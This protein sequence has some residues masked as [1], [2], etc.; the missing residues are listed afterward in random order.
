MKGVS[1]T[2]LAKVLRMDLAQ[3]KRRLSVVTPMSGAKNQ[4]KYDLKT[5]LPH[6]VDPVLSIEEYLRHMDP[7]DLPPKLSAHFWQGQKV[8]LQAME[9]AGQL[10]STAQVI[11]VFG[12]VFKTLRAQTSLWVD[13]LEENTEITDEQ[14]TTLGI[15]IDNM[16]KEILD[17][18]KQFAKENA[19]RSQLEWLETY[20]EEQGS[21]Q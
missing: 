5:A 21:D 20:A 7:K 9:A 17:E 3:V 18:M 6:L 10:W 15:L 13:T 14:R 1:S 16:N 12:M 11:E 8:R 4:A 2:W 19:T